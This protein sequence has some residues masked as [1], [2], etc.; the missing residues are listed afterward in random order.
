MKYYWSTENIVSLHRHLYN[1]EEGYYMVG[2]S[3][4]TIW[5]LRLS[6]MV[7]QAIW[8]AIS[9]SEGIPLYLKNWPH[10]SSI[11]VRNFFLHSDKEC[12]FLFIFSWKYFLF[13]LFPLPP[14]HFSNGPSLSS[15]NHT[16]TDTN[17]DFHTQNLAPLRLSTHRSWPA[18]PP[19]PCE[20]KN[21]VP[22]AKS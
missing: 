17:T 16:N 6:E 5:I 18:L 2:S 19:L 15:Q 20:L 7:F 9:Y 21:S 4:E 22:L 8:A 3:P 11:L 1:G 14:H 13:L 10:P 12:N